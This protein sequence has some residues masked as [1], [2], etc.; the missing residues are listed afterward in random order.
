MDD[1]HR[2]TNVRGS[3]GGRMQNW[4]RSPSSS[5]MHAADNPR[6]LT[7]KRKRKPS[8]QLSPELDLFD[9]ALDYDCGG[10][11]TEPLLH[12]FNRKP[13]AA[14]S[15][16]DIHMEDADDSQQEIANTWDSDGQ[17][18]QFEVRT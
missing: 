3:R 6:P 2:A 13:T 15:D 16:D 10:A 9:I 17:S 14:D 18:S 5:N 8:K 1:E 7:R 12:R 4:S 11:D